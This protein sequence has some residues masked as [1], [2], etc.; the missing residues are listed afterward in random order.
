MHELSI[1]QS[2]LEI[3]QDE[4]KKHGADRLSVVKLRLG[5]LTAI[6]PTSLSFCFDLIAKG[7]IA[8]GAR[9]EIETV[10]ITGQCKQCGHKFIMEFPV[11]TCPGCQGL[12]ISILT[13]REFYISEIETDGEN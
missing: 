1:A 10:P 2:I 11:G 9:I 6:E 13:G 8:E 7:T 12:C 5:K 4:A 3:V